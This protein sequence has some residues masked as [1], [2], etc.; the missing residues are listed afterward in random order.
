[1]RG[2]QRPPARGDDQL[3]RFV[4]QAVDDRAEQ[5]RAVV[6]GAERGVDD[7][8]AAARPGE[9]PRRAP[10]AV[11][12]RRP[13][14]HTRRA[15]LAVEARRRERQQEVTERAVAAWIGRQAELGTR[16]VEHVGDVAA[17]GVRRAPRVGAHDRVG[18]AEHLGGEVAAVLGSV[19]DDHVRRPAR[20]EP[21]DVGDD[22]ARRLTG[23]D[24]PP[25]PRVALGA[26]RDRRDG[27]EH[28]RHVDGQPRPADGVVGEPGCG[29]LRGHRRGRGE[30]HVVPGGAQAARD[31]QQRVEVTRAGLR[32]EQEAHPS[33]VRSRSPPTLGDAVTTS[34]R[35]PSTRLGPDPGRPYDHDP[36]ENGRGVRA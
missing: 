1:M 20:G 3:Q 36:D 26:G 32:R 25:R 8:R 24:V 7:R 19:A 10:A 4:R 28:P 6:D 13:Q 33:I 2:G 15:E 29:D 27:R 14:R 21:E 34:W 12:G 31:G 35:R 22:V 23:E 18:D 30:R 11:C 5:L 9:P 17:V 16:F